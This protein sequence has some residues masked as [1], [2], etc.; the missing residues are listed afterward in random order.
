MPVMK[1]RDTNEDCVKLAFVENKLCK[2]A[3]TS[4]I[5]EKSVKD[6][7]PPKQGVKAG[8]WEVLCLPGAGFDSLPI[9]QE[10]L[11]PNGELVDVMLV[12]ILVSAK[13]KT[14]SPHLLPFLICSGTY[15]INATEATDLAVLSAAKFGSFVINN[16][17]LRF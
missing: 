7:S 10:T 1:Q 12:M 15:V 14:V 13:C 3:N 16:A 17:N 8:D 2:D 4:F 9:H 11:K 6:S 5:E